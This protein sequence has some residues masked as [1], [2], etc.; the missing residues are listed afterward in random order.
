M[1]ST[2]GQS[3]SEKIASFVENFDP[4]IIRSELRHIAARAIYDT[5]VCA[6]AG[7]REPASRLSL[8]YA[9]GHT[10]P[11][12]ATAWV[13]GDRLSLEMAALVN[14]TTGH[15]LDFD[16]VSS[17]LRGHPTVAMI[18][19]LLALGESIGAQG[20]QIIDAY[21][22]G[23]E[24]ALRLARAMVDDHY[25][26]GW[27]STVSVASFGATAA[28][29]YLLKLSHTQI[30]HALGVTVSQI[31]GTR[32]NF[33]T[34]SK[35]FQAGQANAIALRAVSLAELGF[36]ASAQAMD[37]KQGYTALY[38]DSRDI[39]AQLDGLGT[40]PLE[41]ERSGIEIKKYPLC[42][43]THRTIDGLLD[44]LKEHTLSLEKIER[45]DIKTNFRATVPLIYS[46]PQSGLEG[47]FSMQYAVTAALLDGAVLLSSF[48]DQA[49][50]RPS[51]QA[52]MSKV[53]VS[54][55]LPPMFPRWAEIR[56]Q[57]TDGQTIHKRVERLRGSTE[58]PLS[59]EALI[60]K[61]LDCCRYGEHFVSAR[62][63]ASSCFALDH[64]P[65]SA[66]IAVLTGQEALPYASGS[67]NTFLEPGRASILAYQ[68]S[69]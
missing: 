32:Q 22:V 19:A 69:I 47:K 65:V 38:A 7:A 39:H 41:L 35:P 49:V 5:V 28:C 24:V 50:E 15:A 57:L 42:Y 60:E 61:G 66:L 21:V 31:A 23:F 36:D 8:K 68:A 11:R 62:D 44:I 56:I 48:E 25:A 14:G 33:G 9:Y 51:V 13:T 1:N 20:R 10:G 17:P 46:Q 45:V 12:M 63:L 64:L 2:Y 53:H 27:H 16:D 29:A 30:V 59:D 4:A 58:L 3:A 40:L 67:V 18:P 43:A 6:V 34:M 37:G 52:F 55:G 54:E 26:K